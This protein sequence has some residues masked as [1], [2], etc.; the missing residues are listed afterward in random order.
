MSKKHFDEYFNSVVANYKEMLDTIHELEE[1]CNKGLV[2]PDK[3]ENM[4]ELVKPLKENYLTLSWVMYLL[5]QPNKAKKKRTYERVA[6]PQ[7]DKIDPEKERHP[8][9]IIKENKETIENIK[10]MFE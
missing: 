3:L 2:D 9:A 8:D 1:E 5:N 10:T 4:K 6:L 7:M